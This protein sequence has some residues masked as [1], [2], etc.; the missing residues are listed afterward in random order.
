M[1]DVTK[2]GIE[3]Q[4]CARCKRTGRH[5]MARALN[6]RYTRCLQLR[7]GTEAMC[8]YEQY[9]G[10]RGHEVVVDG[11]WVPYTEVRK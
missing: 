11:A 7:E 9:V 4:Y 8:G 5:H 6:S 2:I 10:P 1:G 3:N